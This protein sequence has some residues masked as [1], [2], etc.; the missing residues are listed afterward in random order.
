M[1]PEAFRPGARRRSQVSVGL[2]L[3][4]GPARNVRISHLSDRVDLLSARHLSQTSTKLGDYKRDAQSLSILRS[5]A[6]SL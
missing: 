2:E 3:P 1:V 4:V 5:L 6:H